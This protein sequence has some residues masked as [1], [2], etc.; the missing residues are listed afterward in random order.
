VSLASPNRRLSE[1]DARWRITQNRATWEYDCERDD[2]RNVIEDRRRL[3][4]RTSSPPRR[5]LVED[6]AP[7]GKSGFCALAG[8]LRQVRWSDK[9]KTDN[10]DKY[11]GSSNPEKFIQVYQTVNE[12]ARE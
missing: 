12:A 11:D 2:L 5:S 7:I 10:I 6:V 4:L 1:H 8:P 9:F 3:M